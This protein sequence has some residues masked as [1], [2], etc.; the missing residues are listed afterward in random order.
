LESL[1]KGKYSKVQHV[2]HK[3]S[4]KVCAWAMDSNG[5]IVCNQAL[6]NE[7]KLWI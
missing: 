3:T 6:K 5:E 2:Q 7:I 4:L 1:Q